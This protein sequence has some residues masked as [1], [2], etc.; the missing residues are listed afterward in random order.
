S[1]HA[2]SQQLVL[3]WLLARSPAIL[4][5]PGTGSVAHLEANVAAAGLRLDPSE[6]H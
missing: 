3:A 4:P 2:T 5:I 1:H 6:V